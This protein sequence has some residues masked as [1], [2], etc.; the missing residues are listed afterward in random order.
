MI[1]PFPDYAASIS[2][3]ARRLIQARTI[4]NLAHENPDGDAIGCALALHMELR[5][6]GREVNTYFPE[7]LPQAYSWLPGIEG[8]EFTSRLPDA[9]PD[10]VLV[11]DVASFARLGPDLVSQL[12]RLGLYPAGAPEKREAAPALVNIDHHVSNEM[13]GDVNLVIPEAA[14]TAEI[15]VTLFHEMEL[16]IPVDAATNLY[17][18]L[19]TDT[20]RF[21]Y[22]NTTR[23]SFEI[24]AE[25]VSIGVKP[26]EIAQAIY[27]QHTPAEHRLLGRVLSQT[28]VKEEFGYFYS[29]ISQEMLE[30]YQCRMADTESVIDTLRTLA[31]PPV[32]F[33]FKEH[34]DGVIKVSIRSRN[35][36]DAN[37]FASRFGGGG[38]SGASGFSFKGTL[39]EAFAAVE[40]AMAERAR[41]EKPERG[42]I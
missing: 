13:F 23:T 22:P 6:P 31:S 36:F 35:D 14:A 28:L 30:E 16:Q 15:V 40:K 33:L 38:H 2:E 12:N 11:N 37:V 8:I 9:L 42:A 24:A 32:C 26:A 27:N 4:W 39:K 41:G 20:G 10:I 34:A 3:V 19:L 17:V 25:L 5:G 18:A 1:N 21:C 7:P 29:F